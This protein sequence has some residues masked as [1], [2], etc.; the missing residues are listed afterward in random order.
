MKGLFLFQKACSAFLEVVL[1]VFVEMIFIVNDQFFVLFFYVFYILTQY[2][3]TLAIPSRSSNLGGYCSTVES[4]T[5]KNHLP[6]AL[7]VQVRHS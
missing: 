5:P 2:N 1:N 7:G 4:H 3:K 6:G